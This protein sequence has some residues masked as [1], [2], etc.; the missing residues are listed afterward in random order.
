MCLVRLLRNLRT[1]RS[2][3]VGVYQNC[4]CIVEE[5]RGKNTISK[6]IYQDHDFDYQLIGV[7]SDS[8]LPLSMTKGELESLIEMGKFLTDINSATEYKK[9]TRIDK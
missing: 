6:I 5:C 7:L 3:A 8:E 4:Q 1:P 2:S 9:I